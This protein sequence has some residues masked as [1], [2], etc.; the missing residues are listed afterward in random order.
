[1]TRDPDGESRDPRAATA[2][3]ILS[4]LLVTLP[5]AAT[6]DDGVALRVLA[7]DLGVA[8]HRLAL[9][10][11]EVYNRGFYL[12]AG[13]GDQITLALD[14]DRV[15]VRTTGEFRRPVGLTAPEAVALE[16]GMRMVGGAGRD[17]TLS[18][19]LVSALSGAHETPAGGIGS[20]EEI[21]V[22]SAGDAADPVVPE[23]QTALR[24]G[25]VLRFTYLGAGREVEATRRVLPGLLVHAEGVWYVLGRDLDRE[26]PRV[27]RCD[28]ILAVGIEPGGDG[29]V[30]LSD[31]ERAAFEGY[32]EEG[33]VWMP[34]EEGTAEPEAF[35]PF[36]EARVRYDADIAPWIRER[37][38]AGMR[39]LPGGA[40]EVTHR[41]AAM[42]WIVRHVLSYGGSAEVLSPPEI[43]AQLA[44]AAETLAR[45]PGHVDPE[46]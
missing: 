43:R 30:P 13:M 35:P 6:S 23:V 34:P 21:G 37:G 4:R 9:D 2:A 42:D 33:R 27:F 5:L 12:R 24:E 11:T 32:L 45:G 44:S 39:E 31:D 25:A 26:A 28:R 15:R 8:P 46:G 41:V 40:L 22:D 29:V 38:Y 19:R 18:R 20:P 7:D 17:A 14:A 16:L 3:A 1:V 10:F 36:V